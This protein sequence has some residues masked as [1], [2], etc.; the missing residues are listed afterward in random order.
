MKILKKE[1]IKG[2]R[3]AICKICPDVSYAFPK[4]SETG[5]LT[6][7]IRVKHLQN[8][9]WQTQISTFGGTLSTFSYNRQRGK[10]N[11][12]KYLIQAEQ[13]FSFAENEAF[14]N[15]IRTTHNPEYNRS[16]KILLERKCPG[17]LK[18]ENKL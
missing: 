4:N 12:T 1:T 11:L 7:H 8:Q 14:T 13:P 2:V 3:K 16:L 9:S 18:K 10:T 6:R 15:F 17:L 5:P